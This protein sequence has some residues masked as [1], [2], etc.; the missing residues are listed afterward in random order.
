M[1]PT[2]SFFESEGVKRKLTLAKSIPF[3]RF[4]SEKNNLPA[5]W[6]ERGPP[7]KA[8]LEGIGPLLLSFADA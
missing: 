4:L 5:E 3:R 7:K 6:E 1:R 8:R 2:L